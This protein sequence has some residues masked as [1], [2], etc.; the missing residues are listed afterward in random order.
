M[1]VLSKKNGIIIF[2]EY[3]KHNARL[4]TGLLIRVAR[5][6]LLVEQKLVTLTGAPEF[7]PSIVGF[8]LLHVY[9]SVWCFVDHYLTFCCS[10]FS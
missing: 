6:I 7:N 2:N 10:S 3:Y 4:T 9:F 1:S 8:E 5:R